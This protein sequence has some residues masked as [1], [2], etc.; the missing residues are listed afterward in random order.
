MAK[1]DNLPDYSGLLFLI[2]YHENLVSGRAEGWYA[3]F[4]P[5]A[6][7][8]PA[9]FRVMRHSTGAGLA[10]LSFLHVPTVKRVMSGELGRNL[11]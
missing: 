1:R 6:A 11:A 5:L 10:L 8:N 2:G 9:L 4:N 3:F 7:Q